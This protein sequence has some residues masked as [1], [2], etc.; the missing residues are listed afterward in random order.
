MDLG[1]LEFATSRRAELVDITGRVAEALRSAGV[2]AGLLHVFCPHTTAGVTIQENADPDVGRDLL[3]A[4]ENAVPER[5]SGGSYRHAEGNSDAHVKA[6]LVGSSQLVPVA[7]GA[8]VLGTWQGI[9]LCE[10]DGP[11][12]RQVQLTFIPA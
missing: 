9:F 2:G 7:R 11:R 5:A 10:F 8:M 6:C 3:L 12:R 4:L 1:R